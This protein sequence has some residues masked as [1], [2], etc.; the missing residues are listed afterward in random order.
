MRVGESVQ[1]VIQ[2]DN[3]IPINASQ[4]QS[5]LKYFRIQGRSNMEQR[6][7]VNG[8][9][10]VV[11]RLIIQAS[12]LQ[13]GIFAIPAMRI[14]NQL[15][16][17]V[18]FTV[19]NANA[20]SAPVIVPA[21][22][23]GGVLVTSELEQDSVYV[24]SEAYVIFKLLYKNRIIQGQ[25]NHLALANTPVNL[26]VNEKRSQTVIQNENYNVSEWKYAFIP[27][28]SG[29]V[30]IPALPFRGTV[31]TPRGNQR[32]AMQSDPLTLTVKPIPLDWPADAD[33]L[34]AH[35]LQI[36]EKWEPS[37]SNWS[38]NQPVKRTIEIEAL[39]I[40]SSQFPD[41][42]IT[43]PAGMNLYPQQPSRSD[44]ITPQGNQA[45]LTLTIDYIAAQQGIMTLA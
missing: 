13:A 32:V 41:L 29:Q 11:N 9:V 1:I 43:A 16:N 10:T 22:A 25:I 19:V 12:P 6:Q 45:R 18:E 23:S 2:T 14:G 35:S 5:I 37:A 27:Q 44:Q 34:P 4:F 42:T 3:S 17:R 36:W 31:A 30:S 8:Q 26:I 33:W 20:N 28:R 39:G 38:L 40:K 7:I 21:N 15:T 24:G